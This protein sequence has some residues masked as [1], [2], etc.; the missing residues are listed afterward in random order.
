MTKERL[1]VIA[2]V[3]VCTAVCAWI[4]AEAS[5]ISQSTNDLSRALVVATTG[6]EAFKDSGLAKETAESL[7]GKALGEKDG[8]V[9]YCENWLVSA[10]A[11]A[12]YAMRFIGINNPS[13][14]PIPTAVLVVETITG[15]EIIAFTVAAGD[16]L[17]EGNLREGGGARE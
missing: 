5:N 2:M 10:Q 14:M 16:G 11:N 1:A 12:A 17:R 13:D 15:R 9:F 6:A 8:I 7:G 4:F 3:L